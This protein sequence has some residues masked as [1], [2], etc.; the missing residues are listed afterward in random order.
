MK[1]NKF[2]R[3]LLYFVYGTVLMVLASIIGIG[4][5]GRE[6]WSVSLF[7]LIATIS[8]RGLSL[9]FLWYRVKESKWDI[10][11]YPLSSMVLLMAVSQF[12]V[13]VFHA[14]LLEYA[15]YGDFKCVRYWYNYLGASI[16]LGF[17]IA[18]FVFYLKHTGRI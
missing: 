9:V 11:L 7:N 5:F 17:G 14:G 8:V 2:Y 15:I 1:G 12:Y 13:F 6:H 3:T 4:I 16:D 10:H 18:Y